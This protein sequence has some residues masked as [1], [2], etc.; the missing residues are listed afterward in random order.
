[1]IRTV[2]AFVFCSFLL[3]CDRSSDSP[4]FQQRQQ[5]NFLDVEKLTV[6]EKV[7][8]DISIDDEP[9]GRVVIGLFGNNVPATARNFRILSTGEQGLGLADKPLDYTGSSFHRIVPGFV[10]QGGDIIKGDGT[11]G[12]SIYGATF[13]DESFAIPH[14]RA[15][16]VSMANRGPDTNSSQFFITLAPAPWLNGRHVVFGK[17]LEGDAVI[18]QMTQQAADGLDGATKVPVVITEAG[19]FEDGES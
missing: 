18:D 19:M 16:L 14:D 7:Y 6:T 2:F 4:T 8:F 3:S 5:P 11:G 13:P 17:V 9:A 12:E 15:G 10:V 1:M